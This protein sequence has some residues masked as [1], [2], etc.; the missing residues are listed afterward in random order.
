MS[1]QVNIRLSEYFTLAEFNVK[2]TDEFGKPSYYPLPWVYPNGPLFHVLQRVREKTGFPVRITS[3]RRDIEDH[4]RVYKQIASTGQKSG[5]WWE[6]IT[7]NSKH[8]PAFGED[9]LRAVDIKC[10]RSHE[11]GEYFTGEEIKAII[12]D[13]VGSSE[14]KNLYG[15]CFYGLGVG[16]Q[17]VHLDFSGRDKNT[18]WGYNY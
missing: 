3:G 15:N 2:D 18:E 11:P 17:Y 16:R 7:W 13:I 5:N 4:I 10:R 9:K 12:L 6:I 8:L 14:F 1:N